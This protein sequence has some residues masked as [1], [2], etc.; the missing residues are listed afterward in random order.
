MTDIIA[1]LHIGLADTDPSIWRRVEVPVE[2]NLKM[3]HDVIQGAMGW[4]DY[5]LWEFEAGDKRYGVAD[6]GWDD[7]GLLAAKNTKLKVLLDRDVHQFL[8]TYDMG[9]N[10][11]HI[12]TLEAVEEGQPGTRYP[13]YIEGEHRAPPEDCGGTL[14]FEAFLDAVSDPRHPEHKDATE[15]HH[16]CYGKTFDHDEIDERDANLRIAAIAKRRAAGKPSR[17]RKSR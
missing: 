9:D 8:Y 11:E 13:R 16:G 17:A 14:G 15:W 6:P 2:G 10:W 1:R 4:L 7:D 12:V 5:H 3:L